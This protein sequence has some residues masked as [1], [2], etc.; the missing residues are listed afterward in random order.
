[1]QNTRATNVSNVQNNY[2]GNCNNCSDSDWDGGSA[3][4]G[5]VAGAMVVGAATAATTPPP[6]PTAVVVAAPAPAPV[7]PPCNVAPVAVKD[8][9][10]YQCGATWYA[11]GYG[12]SGVVYM[13]VQPPPGY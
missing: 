7:G 5:F 3:A 10:Y 1:M 9:S 6:A 8:V 2:N 13:P 12:S 11:A 4:V